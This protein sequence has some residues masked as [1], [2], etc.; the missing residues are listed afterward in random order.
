MA[1]VRMQKKYI[2]F[3]LGI[4]SFLLIILFTDL[5]PGNPEVTATLAVACLMAI[6]WVSETIPLSVTAL[7]PP[8]L[9][10][11]FGVLDGK[12]V[13]GVYMN[14][15]IF[16]YVGG[17]M[18]VMSIV[19][20]LEESL[21]VKSVNKY[22]TGLFLAIVYSA[23]IGGMSTLVLPHQPG[24]PADPNPPLSICARDLLYQLDGLCPA[25]IS[26][27]AGNGLAGGPHALPAS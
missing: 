11:A 21:S 16:V 26:C 19:V 22:A 3:F 9:F 6:W 13:S 12:T 20:S 14:H 27:H 5:K 7:V 10:P 18:M 24:L 15:I 8:V 25:H 2:G 17:F 1:M 4:A 23:S